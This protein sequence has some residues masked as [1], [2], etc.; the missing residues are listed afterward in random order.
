MPPTPASPR[1]GLSQGLSTLEASLAAEA[2]GVLRNTESHLDAL[3]LAA[4][5]LARPPRARP[6]EPAPPPSAADGSES[7]DS[8]AGP[9]FAPP[10]GSRVALCDA[11]R[12][13]GMVEPRPVWWEGLV[14]GRVPHAADYAGRPVHCVLFDDLE[15]QYTDRLGVRE[16]HAEEGGM[17]DVVFLSATHARDC[18]SG[19]ELQYRVLL[20]APQGA[21]QALLGAQLLVLP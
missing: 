21:A 14:T 3:R 6:A 9:A 2:A 12:A 10:L 13:P 4:L 17:H 19:E 16:A 7:E 8:A 5:S 11:F 20:G 1:A 18:D 15:V